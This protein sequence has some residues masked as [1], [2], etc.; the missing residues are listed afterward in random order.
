MDYLEKDNWAH[1]LKRWRATPELSSKT[2]F[3]TFLRFIFFNFRLKTVVKN[4][5]LP[6]LLNKSG[7]IGPGVV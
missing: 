7:L 4:L 3:N 2:N 6:K 5:E 1:F